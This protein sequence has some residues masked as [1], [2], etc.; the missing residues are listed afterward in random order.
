MSAYGSPA[1]INNGVNTQHDL[2][3]TTKFLSANP[4]QAFPS[5]P[6]VTWWC[7]IKGFFLLF[8]SSVGKWRHG[9]GQ[10]LP[11]RCSTTNNSAWRSPP[12]TES[13]QPSTFPC[14]PHC[15]LGGLITT[16]LKL[17]SRT[18]QAKNKTIWHYLAMD[19]TCGSGHPDSR[20]FR[21][22]MVFSEETALWLKTQ[23][24]SS[25]SS[26]P[27][28]PLGFRG[29]GGCRGVPMCAML[30]LSLLSVIHLVILS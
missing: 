4:H 14:R 16:H 15:P 9:S 30:W 6:W 11:E 28:L 26:Q 13:L 5:Y 10:L 12:E 24:L 22:N 19:L 2:F 25:V 21:F 3:I 7:S 27:Y 8:G 29:I 23:V 20:C 18:P 17:G 1:I